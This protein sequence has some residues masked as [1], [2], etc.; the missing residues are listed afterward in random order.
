ML[1]TAR[2]DEDVVNV[3]FIAGPSSE[4]LEA[5]LNNLAERPDAEEEG[6]ISLRLLR[7]Y[8]TSVRHH[9]YYGVDIVTMRVEPI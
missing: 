7:H 3:E 2:R 1:I 6:N 5:R 9:S 4:N 8:A